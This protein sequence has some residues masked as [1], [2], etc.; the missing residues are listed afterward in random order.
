[1]LPL[2]QRLFDV[3]A[4]WKTCASDNHN[5]YLLEASVAIDLSM[6]KSLPTVH[7]DHL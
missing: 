6:R 1:L 2:Q 5:Y 4:I 7:H 3:D